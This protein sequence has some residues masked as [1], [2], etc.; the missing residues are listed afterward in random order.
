ME[1]KI[2]NLKLKTLNSFYYLIIREIGI[3]VFSFIGQIIL[4]RILYPADFGIFAILSFIIN[5]LQLITNFGFSYSIVQKERKINKTEIN[6]IFIFQEIISLFIILFIFLYGN[7]IIKF[8]PNIK[9]QDIFLLKIFSLSLIIIPYSNIVI[10]ILERKLNYKKVSTV[11]TF[12]VLVYEITAI[13]FSLLHFRTISLILGILAKEISQN[14]LLFILE[15][16]I[17][18]FKFNFKKIKKFL[19]FGFFIQAQG[20][21]SLLSNSLNPLLIGK[22]LGAYFVGIVDF[23]SNI[24]YVPQALADNLGRVSFSS[25]S[26]AN[27]NKKYMSKMINISLGFISTI[28]FLIFFIILTSGKALINFIFTARWLPSLTSVYFFTIAMIFYSLKTPLIQ[29]ILAFGNSKQYFK[30]NF[31]IFLIQLFLSIFLIKYFSYNAIS[32][33]VAISSIIS[34]FTYL[35]II[36]NNQIEI[37]M[38]KQI[39]PKFFI[40]IISLFFNFGLSFYFSEINFVNKIILDTIF[41]SLSYLIFCNYELKNII[42]EFRQK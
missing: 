9:P 31:F 15:P 6:S 28:T 13:F 10:S 1:K 23:A 18:S 40:L 4:A 27:K 37:Q 41:Y 26:R 32:I 21:L 34:F 19:R 11:E 35:K 29:S 16:F 8:F 20:F 3:K 39:A 24:A 2:K 14:I 5:F 42:N 7:L 30:I 17:P 33:S 25:F 22:L 12:G 38:I 36:K